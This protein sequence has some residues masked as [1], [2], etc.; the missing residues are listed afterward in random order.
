MVQDHGLLVGLCWLAIVILAHSS[1]VRTGG[2]FGCIWE[3][4]MS[5][6]I[7]LNTQRLDTASPV[8]AHV[9][10][11]ICIALLGA[12]ICLSIDRTPFSRWDAW[13]FGF[14]P[15]LSCGAVILTFLLA[16][17]E[18]R[19][20]YTLENT[21]ATTALI[22]C[23]FVWWIRPSC[24]KTQPGPTF[25]FGIVP[26]ILLLLD[27]A[28]MGINQSN[29]FLSQVVLSPIPYL[30]NNGANFFFAQVVLLCL[31]LGALRVLKCEIGN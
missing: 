23:V 26:V 25:L 10:A 7:T 3:V 9:N 24:W 22:L 13:F 17:A 12:Y 21:I 14:A 1:W 8:L 27:I 16:P 28:N 6:D 2:I 29:F 20:L 19:S 4:F 15:I 11:A 5:I 18:N 31:L 30:A